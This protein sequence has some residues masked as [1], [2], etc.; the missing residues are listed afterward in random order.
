MGATGLGLFL[1]LALTSYLHKLVP[2][3]EGGLYCPPSNLGTGLLFAK[4]C[5]HIRFR[6]V[7]LIVAPQS[8]LEVPVPELLYQFLVVLRH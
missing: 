6:G 3:E 2:F 5:Y 8:L 4:H 7:V 1:F